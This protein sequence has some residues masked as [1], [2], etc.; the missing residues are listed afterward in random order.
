MNGLVRRRVVSIVLTLVI[1]IAI[2]WYVVDIYV[3]SET[4]QEP[5]GAIFTLGYKIPFSTGGNNTINGTNYGTLW[6]M[7]ASFHV[8]N[9]S[10]VL[11]GNWTSTI[12]VEPIV[13]GIN[14]VK[15]QSSMSEALSRNSME[16]AGGWNLVLAP[17]N[18][19]ILFAT[20]P[21]TSGTIAITGAVELI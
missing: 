14:D 8:N 13:L 3:H 12:A 10:N 9:G 16:K 6:P 21:N 7:S 1:L 4:T 15:N 17:G 11:I 2:T 20:Q 5:S 18:Y 19:F